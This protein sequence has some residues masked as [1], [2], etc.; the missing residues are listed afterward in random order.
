M[1]TYTP[2]TIPKDSAWDRFSIREYI[3]WKILEIFD[4]I[5][6][7]LV[8]APTIYKNKDWDHM[9]IYDVLK[10]KLIRQR[11]YLV[12][13]NRHT[14]ISDTNKYITICLNLIERIRDDYYE[15]ERLDYTE[16]KFEWLDEPGNK[17]LKRLK[18]NHISDTYEDYFKK[19]PNEFKKV[20]KNDNK[21]Y[22]HWDKETQAM[23]LGFRMQN[24][25][26]KLLFKILEEKIDSWWD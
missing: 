16:D 5:K 26:K 12:E 23:E 18:I 10:F 17:E 15:M 24:K 19:Y 6:N 14:G 21:R 11:K 2:L 22:V 3:H 25:C 9:Y 7:I 20:L 1:K 13:A 8:W 4:G